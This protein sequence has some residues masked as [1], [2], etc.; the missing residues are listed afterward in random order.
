MSKEEKRTKTSKSAYLNIGHYSSFSLSASI[1]LREIRFR[2]RFLSPANRERMHTM[3]N[4]FV[5]FCGLCVLCG[6]NPLSY[7]SDAK[8]PKRSRLNVSSQKHFLKDRGFR[9]MAEFILAKVSTHCL[10]IDVNV[11]TEL[12]WDKAVKP[13][14]VCS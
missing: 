12:R 8:F 5:S 7:F 13:N 10:T 4:T 11:N 1:T 6:K 2:F 3:R 9:G 14:I